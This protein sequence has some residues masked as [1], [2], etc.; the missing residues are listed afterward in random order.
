MT[1]Q[2]LKDLTVI[3]LAG[4]LAGPSA[5]MFFAEL[6]ARV[7]KIE[8][9]ETGGDVTRSWKLASEDPHS[10]VS[11]YYASVNWNKEVRFTNLK[12]ESGK[13]EVYGLITS[14][15]IVITNFKTGDAEKMGFDAGSLF[16]LN[17]KLIYAA[18]S[19]FGPADRRSAFDLVLQAESGFMSMNGT[20]DS[21]P[22]KMPV[23]MIDILAAHQLKEGIL[24]ALLNRTK[25]GKG[26][27]V[28]VSLF[29]AAVA[30]LANQASNF[31]MTGTIPQRMGSLHPNIAPYGE[32]FSCSDGREIVLAVGSDK[33]FAALCSLLGKKEL[34]NDPRFSANASRVVHRQALQDMLSGIFPATDSASWL[35]KLAEHEIPAGLIRNLAEV[36]DDES[37]RKLILEAREQGTA[38]R[39]VRSAIFSIT[40]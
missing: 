16:A 29:D 38:T 28:H 21:G 31:L 37:A 22:L 15:D 30:S 20:Q 26:A 14:A 23:A 34:A 6:G 1:S 12:S 2:F 10:P 32:T 40:C 24:V 18:I 5:G 17:D 13:K 35:K 9:P 25:T 4:V 39:R 7:I 33:Q 36:F 3:E 19:G 11:A 27:Q 8:N